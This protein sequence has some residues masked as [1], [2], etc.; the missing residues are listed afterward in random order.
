MKPNIIKIDN[1][2][3]IRE[4]SIYAPAQKLDDMDYVILRTYSAGVH[5]GYLKERNGKEGTLLH[6]RRIWYWEGAASLSQLSQEGSKLPDQCKFPCEIPKLEL[7]EII[8]VIYC[9]E[10]ARKFIQELPAWEA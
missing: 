8:E 5:A 2:N 7:T 6:S 3:Y 9:S 4:D 10:M 1:V